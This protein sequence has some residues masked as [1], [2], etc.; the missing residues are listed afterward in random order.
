M[1]Q[2]NN[3]LRTMCKELKVFQGVSYK[4]IAYYLE[5]KTSSFYSWLNEQYDFGFKKTHKLKEI[6]E[7]IKE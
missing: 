7:T 6:I 1:E 3:E 2:L 5:I 4:E